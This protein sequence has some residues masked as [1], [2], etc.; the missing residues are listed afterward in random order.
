MTS[1]SDDFN[2]ANST[3]LGSNWSEDAGDWAINT[4]QLVGASVGAYYKCRWVGTALASNNYDVEVNSE[5]NND[6]R[7]HGPFGRGA[8]SSAVT[9]YAVLGFAGYGFYLVEITAGSESIIQN[10]GT[11]TSGTVYD[12]RLRCDGSSQT[13]YI[14]DA[15]TLSGSDGTLSSGAVGVATYGNTDTV[16]DIIDN[17]AASDLGGETPS[18][19][20]SD[21]VTLGESQTITVSDP[22]LSVSDGVILGD[23]AVAQV[24]DP[25]IGVSDNLTVGESSDVDVVTEE[26]GATLSISVTPTNPVY[27][28]RGV[29]VYP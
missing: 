25:Q 5:T 21:G 4:N 11:C 14:N 9:Y 8:A 22:G 20:V 23:S 26:P 28:V 19:S 29:K 24:S 13:G 18:P 27:Q 17:F 7:G 1:I 2:R 15:S 10:A 16:T 6:S 12:V 3:D